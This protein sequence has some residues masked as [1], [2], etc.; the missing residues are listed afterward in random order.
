MTRRFTNSKPFRLL[1]S[2]LQS[3]YLWNTTVS[4]YQ[5]LQI[6]F[7]KIINFD[8]D[9]RAT[10]VAYSFMLAIFPAIIFLFTL[11]PYVPVRHF[12]VQVMNFLSGVIPVGIYTEATATI[13]EIVSKPRGDI[14][15]FGF[16]LALYASTSGMMAL[17]RAFN[18]TYES[19]ENRGFF[20]SRLIACLLTFLLAFVLLVAILLLIVGRILLD[21]LLEYNMLSTDFTYYAITLSRYLV[22][23]MVSVVAVSIIYY[24]APALH[25]KWRFFNVGSVTAAILIIL[26]TNAF[27]YYIS[28][29]ASYNRLY[30]SIGTLIALM[31]WLYLIA[32]VLILGFDINASLHY[33]RYGAGASDQAK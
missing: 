20:K 22:V 15:S 4:V 28:S 33:A 2:F 3:I 24:W 25:R 18:M 23:F 11:I 13:E 21:M 26:V 10:A 17:M 30:G 14:L 12:D 27:S 29:F 16:I 7:Q 19:V 9:Q 32:L 8:I 5:V 31:I 1:R 6:L